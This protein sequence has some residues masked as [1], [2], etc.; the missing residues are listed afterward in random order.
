MSGSLQIKGNYYYIVHPY[1]NINNET[2]YNWVATKCHIKDGKKAAKAVLEKWKI[3]H[4]GCDM[5]YIKLLFA[6]Y[7]ELWFKDA[8]VDLQPSTVRGYKSKLDNHILPYFKNKNVKLTDLKIR[9]LDEFYLH[10]TREKGLSPQSVRHC[11]RV[12]SKAL[13]E[14]IRKELIAS[15]PASLAKLPKM[16][17]YVGSFLNMA[18]IQQLVQLFKGNAIEYV[19]K[20]ICTYGV[21]RSEALGLCWDKVDFENNQFTISRAFIQG[22]GVN[23]LKECT[24][25]DSSYRTLPL[26]ADMKEMLLFL[27]N[28][29][30]ENKTLLGSAF[31]ENNMVFTWPNG[32]PIIPNYVTRTFHKI[33][34]ESD[35]PT[36]RLHDLRH[37]VETNLLSKGSNVVD[38]QLWLG[39]SQP[40]TTLNYYSHADASSKHNIQTVLERE[41]DFSEHDN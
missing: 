3:E 35:L 24:K 19:V 13:N 15:N 16:Q 21:R 10:L 8:C 39:H 38:I 28:R 9:H 23:Y 33:L 30:E 11:H 7:L 22:D 41:F 1:K 5:A 36:I 17:K 34:E 31:V 37:S 32:E 26:T 20:F 14:A 25:N 18:Q 2:K 12:I 27:K 29:S 40:S 4:A 6:D